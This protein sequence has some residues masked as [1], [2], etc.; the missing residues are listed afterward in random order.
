MKKEKVYRIV[1]V[2]LLLVMLFDIVQPVQLYALTSGPSQP[3]VQ[4]FEPVNTTEMVDPFTGD[5]NYNIPLLTVPGP[6]G[7]YPI[8]IAYHAGI[9][10]EQEA[11][12][13]GLGWNLNVGALNRSMRGLPDDFNGEKV[14]K[15][16]SMRPQINA[17]FGWD[18]SAIS[19]FTIP[20]LFGLPIDWS[21]LTSTTYNNSLGFGYQCY[22]NNYSGVGLSL[23]MTAAKQTSRSTGNNF[24]TVGYG[25]NL[26]L[27][28]QSGA[29]VQ[30]SASFGA[31]IADQNSLFTVSAGYS[32][33]QG[34]YSLGLNMS[35]SNSKVYG[36]SSKEYRANGGG[37]SFAG[38]NYVPGITTPTLGFNFHYYAKIGIGGAG[39]YNNYTTSVFGSWNDVYQK[40]TEMQAYG[41]DY[42]DIRASRLSDDPMLMDINR[43]NEVPVTR[44]AP[45][46]PVPSFTSDSYYATGQ[47]MG[48]GFRPYRS[49]IGVLY[50]PKSSSNNVR[51]LIGEETS[52]SSHL[53]YNVQAGYSRGYSGKWNNDNDWADIETTYQFLEKNVS[54]EHLAYEPFYF[55][56]PSEMS[57]T[58]SETDRF[59]NTNEESFD[60][61][62]VYAIEG[63]LLSFKPKVKNIRKSDGDPYLTGNI[64]TKRDIRSTNIEYRSIEQLGNTLVP[65]HYNVI[66][67]ANTFPGRN[68]VNATQVD[69]SAYTGGFGALESQ[70]GEYT[71]LGNDGMRYEYGLPAFNK[72]QK[73]VMFST[74]EQANTLHYTGYDATDASIN[75]A[76]GREQL[77]S[78]T[79]LPPYAYSYLLTAVYS[80]DYVDLKGDG[81]TSDDLGY[82][83]K[84]NY[85]RSSADYKWRSPFE[86]A[87]YSP[88]YHSDA[89]DDKASYV[90]GEKEIWYLN[91]IETKTHIAEFYLSDRN[92][93]RAPAL[94]SAD[95]NT[96]G[97]GAF[98]KK[99]DRIE[100]YSKKD[101]TTPLKKVNFAYDYSLCKG[102]PN[103]ANNTTQNPN[104]E[105]KLTLQK[106]W[107]EHQNNTKGKL[108]PYQFYYRE[109]QNAYNPNYNLLQ[110]DR[111]GMY[112][113]DRAVSLAGSVNEENPY[114]TQDN[115]TLVDQN[116][117]AW[118][119]Y[120]ITL[121]S[122]GKITVDYEADDYAYVQDKEAT[123]MF[124]I[125]HTGSTDNH[126]SSEKQLYSNDLP[127]P[128]VFN[129]IYFKLEQTTSSTSELQKYISGI[130]QMYFKSYVKLK[131]YQNASGQWIDGYDYVEGF[132]EI[133]SINFDPAS[134]VTGGYSQAY[135][136]VKPVT[137]LQNS[138]DAGIVHPF[139]KA[140]WEYMKVKR[141]DLLYQSLPINTN[142]SVVS[143]IVGQL[144]SI[145]YSY[146]RNISQLLLGYYTSCRTLGFAKEID[147]NSWHKS[148]IRLKSADKTKCGG[149][150]RV[151]QIKMSD[152]WNALT[153]ADINN[154][155]QTGVQ[156]EATFGDYG[157]EYSYK[158]ETGTYSSG[159][160]SYEPL[161]G[162]EENPLKL[163]TDKFSNGRRFLAN[164]KDFYLVEPI[165]ESYYPA[166]VVGYSRVTI[167]N[168]KH[169]EN[170]SEV[171][172]TT[173]P[174]VTVLQ[175]YTAK[176]FPVRIESSD[177]DEGHY[178][179]G[180]VI[181]F[182]GN[183]SY[184][185]H[186][187]S[188]GYSAW[189]ND[190]HGK[191][192]SVSTYAYQLNPAN[193]P[194]YD[195]QYETRTEYIY[196]TQAADPKKLNNE[197]EVLDA[198]GM[199]RTANIGQQTEFFM[200]MIQHSGF[201]LNVGMQI[202]IEAIPPLLTPWPYPMIDYSEQM[203]RSLVGM[204]VTNQ[205]GVLK[206]VRTTRNGAIAYADNLMFDAL[207][208][209]PLLTSLTN[210]HEQPVYSYSY[211]AH[212]SHSGMGAA[213]S[214]Y[215][216]WLYSQ[217]TSSSGG[218]YNL[219]STIVAS[220]CFNIGDQLE[221][222]LNNNQMFNA[223]VDDIDD[224]ANTIT[225]IDE[226]GNNFGNNTI[227]NLRVV[228]SGKRNLTSA[229]MGHIV[230]L[231]NPVT[232]RQ[233][234]LF[235]AFNQLLINGVQNITSVSY[236]DC[237]TGDAITANVTINSDNIVFNIGGQECQATLYLPE[238]VSSTY[239]PLNSNSNIYF[240][241]FYKRGNSVSIVHL[242]VT[243]NGTTEYY[244]GTWVDVNNCH[245]ECLPDVLD[246]GVV[247][248]ND[249]WD[250]NYIDLGD[251]A[252]AGNG[253]NGSFTSTIS[254]SSSSSPSTGN[255]YKFGRSGIW[256]AESNYLY[257]VERKQSIPE[258]GITTTINTKRD[259]VYKTFAYY[260]WATAN[261]H[262]GTRWT[263]VNT[264][265]NYSPYGF[266]IE[267]RNALGLYSS[268][269][270]G[271]DNSVAT[272]VTSNGT[273]FETA[274][275]GFEDHGNTYSSGH[276]HVSLS[277]VN[278]ALSTNGHTGKHALQLTTGN[279]TANFN[280]IPVVAA[281]TTQLAQS[282][283]S[284]IE[285][286]QYTVCAWFKKDASSP[287]NSVPQITVSGATVISTH[288]L[289]QKIEG[290]Q[291]V[292]VTF[293]TGANPGSVD[294]AF[295]FTNGGTGLLDDVRIQPFQSA[296]KTF[297]YD[298]VTLW[299]SAELD[300]R[301]FA[302]YYNYDEEGSLVQV[303]KETEKG[304]VT[305]KTARNNVAQKVVE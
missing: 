223:W 277:N 63:A 91:S 305:V 98:Q 229:S 69:Y 145:G 59:S 162:G 159:V 131:Q 192:K 269:L 211:A 293:E 173:A 270:Y 172:K 19:Q 166:P 116:A 287:A 281:P 28:P 33:R 215:N 241:R 230:S 158:D 110:M 65:D 214:N 103:N 94:N 7:G 72:A 250:Y 101:R 51:V 128:E 244:T 29:G 140:A 93:G 233:F 90:T 202:N 142:A 247:R 200:D 209:Q 92:D 42:T 34:L 73:E 2:Y 104:A 132:C 156:P 15:T 296:M 139:S 11:S 80:A 294:L 199:Y 79:E 27:D 109:D 242:P 78:A 96:T 278:T 266:D 58:D 111:W 273:Y 137:V 83:A 191:L 248:F 76:N 185:N 212:W 216:F 220:H 219:P 302:T 9:G 213:Y 53:G 304:I 217:L 1:A 186:G 182:V 47:G 258:D 121:P 125:L 99:L 300:N 100:L 133:E 236:T 164:E 5:F 160:A 60:V 81:P 249:T 30:P 290:W 171:N 108:T 68:S 285:N 118:S 264:M 117:A 66:T 301:N 274:F 255:P 74:D 102:V 282:T 50:D 208:G 157:V 22:W 286:K 25:L 262:A 126:S 17:G 237:E 87:L 148:F 243:Q 288:I 41:Y 120:R 52:P 280:S 16:L 20:E 3:E 55:K 295:S 85:Y 193:N 12:W 235:D 44:D 163:P 64:R 165:G 84:F 210:E 170:D 130:D 227:Q 161:I 181:P 253:Y 82:Y 67:Q 257:Q 95:D 197:V 271:Y 18:A 151:K 115:R 124:E 119:L 184:D 105:G 14:R 179:P 298:P 204:K 40:T 180:I 112:K 297:V 86:D 114:V 136:T 26:S 183:F 147:P 48:A 234:P 24:T 222:K 32:T 265:T 127:I 113:Q 256:R 77:Y 129:R 194:A 150:H 254:T 97:L 203:F 231:S 299:L 303:K 149:G 4:S 154:N 218:V 292:E 205:N 143:N 169:E 37:L 206:Q 198:D 56:S 138:G 122:G 70:I 268:A 245:R 46:L 189:I 232:D 35:A 141:P 6:N 291:R 134:A 207:T 188:Q 31:R 13:V 251:P 272:C 267:N 196:Q 153:A 123:Q 263:L 284:L 61:N 260:N 155:N 106:I 75:N 10:M 246:A 283:F 54:N 175:F 146:F 239:V 221:I 279:L 174:G 178:S 144:T 224:I 62:M 21:Q 252:T 176:D 43:E 225:L 71:L 167:Q 45:Y 177:I 38:A 57:A 23:D 49:D 89:L 36:S 88:G 135:V 152:N 261:Q 168:I 289:P 276:G 201:S 8:N 238:D 187:Y 228:R 190:M 195:L 259:G 275:E 39:L 240:Y 107:F 226:R